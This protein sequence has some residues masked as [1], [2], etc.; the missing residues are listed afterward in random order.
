MN[1]F[2]WNSFKVNKENIEND[3]SDIV[4]NLRELYSNYSIYE[5]EDQSDSELFQ[6]NFPFLEKNS[7]K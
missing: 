4:G 1:I 3:D 6:M 7:P 2:I 5:K